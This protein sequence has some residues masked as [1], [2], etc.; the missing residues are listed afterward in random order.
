M[1]KFKKKVGDI[2]WDFPTP[3]FQSITGNFVIR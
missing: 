2:K 1:K 3:Q